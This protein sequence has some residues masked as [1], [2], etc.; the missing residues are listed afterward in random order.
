M[1]SIDISDAAFSLAN[2]SNDIIS[3]ASETLKDNISIDMSSP[4]E[5][6][7]DNI[8]NV[9]VKPDFFQ[10]INKNIIPESI[11]NNT[12]YIIVFIGIISILGLFA[13]NYFVKNKKRVTFQDLNQQMPNQ[14]MPNQQNSYYN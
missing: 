2:V 11:N 9:F 7:K 1:E 4:S 8:S 10:E 5:T 14:Q 13:Y 6:I 12:I 3:F